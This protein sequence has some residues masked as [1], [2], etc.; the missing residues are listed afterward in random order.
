VVVIGVDP[1]A[2]GAVAVLTYG[3]QLVGVWDMPSVQV[4]RKHRVAPQ[5]L[6]PLIAEHKPRQAFVERVGSMPGQ[7][8]ASSFAFGYA[9]GLIEGLLSGLSIPLTFFAPAVW[10]RALGLTADKGAARARAMQAFPLSAGQF[11]R[12]RDAGRAEA[13]LLALHGLRSIHG[14]K[15]ILP[16]LACGDGQ[17]APPDP[18]GPWVIFES[19]AASCR[20]SD[21][22]CGC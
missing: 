8:V 6:V 22:A 7:G 1:G 13:A 14:S 21:S 11:A 12:V 19:L 9:A 18:L 17:H 2:H 4:N 10:K 16:P 5:A 20:N 15:P 3:E